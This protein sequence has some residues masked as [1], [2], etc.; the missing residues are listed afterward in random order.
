MNGTL[1]EQ[2][3]LLSNLSILHENTDIT[4]RDNYFINNYS[5]RLCGCCFHIPIKK[6]LEALRLR[7]F[8][9]LVFVTDVWY[10]KPKAIAIDGGIQ[11]A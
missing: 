3:P 5:T 9:I 7:G 1:F 10:N 4:P 2:C 8:Y 6:K 11:D